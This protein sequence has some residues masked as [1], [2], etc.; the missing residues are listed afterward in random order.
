[1]ADDEAFGKDSEPVR[2]LEHQGKS[3]MVFDWQIQA[4]H[5]SQVTL[6]N[7]NCNWERDG[8]PSQPYVPDWLWGCSG[9]KYV[10]YNYVYE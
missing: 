7:S 8:C 2:R 5:L 1:M 4:T 3:P 9:I 6:K 10:A